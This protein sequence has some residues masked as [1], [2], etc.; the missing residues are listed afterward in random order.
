MP[1]FL[2]VCAI[3]V[4]ALSAS[5]AVLARAKVDTPERV[6]CVQ[7]AAAAFRVPDYAILTLMDVEGGDVGTVSHNRNGTRDLGVLQVNSSWLPHL[8]KFGLTEQQLTH[9]FCA[10]VFAGSYI[11]ARAVADHKTLP[12][13]LA[14]YHSPTPVHQHRYLGLVQKA[15]LRRAAQARSGQTNLADG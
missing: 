9:N 2:Q 8:S 11:L 6:E 15:L 1:R 3:A 13:A 7:R 4:L 14:Y 10:N 5:P 12:R